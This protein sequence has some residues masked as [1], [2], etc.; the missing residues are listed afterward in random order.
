[1]FYNKKWSSKQRGKWVFL[2]HIQRTSK[3]KNTP[4]KN[5]EMFYYQITARH[6]IFFFYGSLFPPVSTLSINGGLCNF[7]P[8]SYSLVL[9]LTSF[10][11]FLSLYL[12]CAC[13]P[14]PHPYILVLFFLFFLF[15]HIH[16]FCLY[17]LPALLILP[18]SCALA[19]SSL[20]HI[21]PPLSFSLSLSSLSPP[22]A[23]SLCCPHHHQA[24]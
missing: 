4:T 11:F 12:L 14:S 21:S 23:L 9:S 5:A 24:C 3:L 1:M 13:Y 19:F 10:L 22:L 7:L 17:L 6:Y 20:L 15:L 18:L 2:S 8:S 16:F